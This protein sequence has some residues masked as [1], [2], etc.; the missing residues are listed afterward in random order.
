MY[1]LSVSLKLG[2]VTLALAINQVIV[3]VPVV[4]SGHPWPLAGVAFAV[5]VLAS[6]ADAVPLQET[7]E[8]VTPVCHCPL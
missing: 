3:F 4:P 8:P 6:I 7:F 2:I 5:Y 1:V